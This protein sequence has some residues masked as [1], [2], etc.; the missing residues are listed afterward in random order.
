MQWPPNVLESRILE[1][2]T[3][4]EKAG[5]GRELEMILTFV[6][7]LDGEV[8]LEL[9][10]TPSQHVS[11]HLKKAKGVFSFEFCSISPLDADQVAIELSEGTGADCRSIMSFDDDDGQSILHSAECEDCATGECK[12]RDDLI[13]DSGLYEEMLRSGKVIQLHFGCPVFAAMRGTSAELQERSWGSFVVETQFK[14]LE[15]NVLLALRRM[16]LE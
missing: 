7:E 16:L 5:F 8:R 6:R 15:W 11:V 2:R 14:L 1:Y 12:T 13:D 10:S 3:A 4:V 9:L